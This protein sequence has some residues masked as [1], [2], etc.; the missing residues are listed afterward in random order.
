MIRVKEREKENQLAASE[1]RTKT[2][3]WR[4]LNIRWYFII[5]MLPNASWDDDS[6]AMKCHSGWWKFIGIFRSWCVLFHRLL[7][8]LTLCILKERFLVHLK[9]CMSYWRCQMTKSIEMQRQKFFILINVTRIKLKKKSWLRF[10]F[11]RLSQHNIDV[12][13]KTLDKQDK[14]CQFQK[15]RRYVDKI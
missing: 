14:C 12:T 5:K 4:Q 1:L 3:S 7:I 8:K 11:S 10:Y 13:F 6:V 15:N 9:H 2:F